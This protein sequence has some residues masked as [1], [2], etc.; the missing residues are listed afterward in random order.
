MKISHD[1]NSIVSMITQESINLNKKLI[2]VD[3]QQAVQHQQ[4]DV[5][6]EALHEQEI[7][8]DLYA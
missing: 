1:I 3:V 6:E 4:N 2:K 7:S 5:V 8:V